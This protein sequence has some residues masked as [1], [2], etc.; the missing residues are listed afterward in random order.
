MKCLFLC[1]A[2]LLAPPAAA[3]EFLRIKAAGDVLS[4][5]AGDVQSV[6]ASGY[7]DAPAIRVRLDP[8][9][10]AAFAAMTARAVGSEMVIFVCGAEVMRASL[11]E[12]MKAADFMLGLPP[13]PP[14]AR[15]ILAQLQ[16]TAC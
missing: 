5:P 13:D 4:V 15:R 8:T 14:K 16:A 1:A 9:H 12:P 7:A 6:V 10:D 2:M 3:E 11:V